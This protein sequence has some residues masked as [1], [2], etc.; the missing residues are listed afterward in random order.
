MEMPKEKIFIV[1]AIVL[2]VLAFT[3]CIPFLFNQTKNVTNGV[4]T[5]K[6]VY[7][8][9]NAQWN[10][11]IEDL[12]ERFEEENPDIKIEY[13]THYEDTVYENF[14]N[15]LVARDEFGD[16]VQL[17]LP[18]AYISEGLIA[19]LSDDLK[20]LVSEDNLYCYEGQAY[21]LGAVNTTSGVLYNKEIFEKLGL[22]IP[23]SYDEFL[24]LCETIKA[25]GI[26]PL[27]CAGLELWHMEF[28]LNH[29]FRSD[30]LSK[31]PDWLVKCSNHEVSWNDPEVY[32][33]FSHM[34]TLFDEG[35]VRENWLTIKDG[36]LPYMM[37]HGDIAMIY[38]G[39]WTAKI[40][41]KMDDSVETGWFYLPDEEG[42]T[43][44]DENKDIFFAVTSSCAEDEKKQ[45][46]ANRFLK[47]IYEDD[48]YKKLYSGIYS[49]P[50]NGENVVS[51]LGGIEEQIYSGFEENENHVYGFIGNEDTPEGFENDMLTEVTNMLSNKQ[52]IEET[53]N[54]CQLLWEKYE[55]GR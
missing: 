30:V 21:A 55:S 36:S 54:K 23:K 29:F 33:M 46:A 43:Y 9:Q 4:T 35:Y 39:P 15:K 48:N 17:K 10:S 19:P 53:M 22:E 47:F 31:D 1:I 28:L 42:N 8:F 18:K 24:S 7:A 40:V 34:K 20:T 51:K 6:F 16:V 32:E 14:L 52:T 41:E 38:T 12:I 26:H 50:T 13:E 2:G 25:N 37:S 49:F 45:D 44:I 5:I 3:L 27:G 11:E